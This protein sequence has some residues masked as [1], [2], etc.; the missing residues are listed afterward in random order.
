MSTYNE[1]SSN[2]SF[3]F[4]DYE[5]S[6]VHH[7]FD[8]VYQFA[9]VRTDSQLNILPGSEVNLLC[10]PRPDVIPHPKAFLTHRIDIRQLVAE[11]MSEFELAGNIQS[12]MMMCTNTK[13]SGYNTMAFD[14][15]MTRNMMYRNLRS[16]YDHEWKDGNQRFDVMK[17]VMMMYALRPDVLNWKMNSDGVESFKLSDMSEANGLSHENAHD[18]LSDVYA[19][20]GLAK[21]IKERNGRAFDYVLNLANKVNAMTMLSK[22]EPLLHIS[23]FYGKQNKCTTM[24]QPIIMD[25]ENKNK[26]LCVDLRHDLTD[27]LYMSSNEMRK[28]LFTS[29]EALPEGSPCVPL[30]GI[31][32]N[33]LP[34]IAEPGRL[35]DDKIADRCN[36]DVDLCH[37]NAA[38]LRNN[39]DFTRRVQEAF[40][41]NMPVHKNVYAQIYTGGFLSKQDSNVR[42]SMTIKNHVGN[43][44]FKIE[45]ADI[46]ESASKT[47]DKVRQFELMLRAKWNNF[48]ENILASSS[49]SAAELQDWSAYIQDRLYNEENASGLTIEGYKKALEMVRIEEV[50]SDEDNEL[51]D[52]VT[53]YI[54]EAE[55]KAKMIADIATSK[56]MSEVADI[57][58]QQ[59]LPLKKIR[60]AKESKHQTDSLSL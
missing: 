52:H 1:Q 28:Y 25:I 16:P 14:D 32:C 30:L 47:D 3:L 33:K 39:S 20:I 58:R 50:L 19:T 24:V 48:S 51:L 4:Y 60:M 26:I 18:A 43:K 17:L 2:G 42:A 12:L 37:R 49:F 15:M 44:E 36:L 38:L 23:G 10:K 27:V 45:K 29:R 5:T 55:S 57:E 7:N 13:I 41:G 21:L 59:S 53:N 40:I 6:G 56:E 22:K 9:G 11:G 34:I 46:F 54:L 8:Q 35:L 31:E